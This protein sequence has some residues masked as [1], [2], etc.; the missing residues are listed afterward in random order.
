MSC[1]STDAALSWLLSLYSTCSSSPFRPSS[2]AENFDNFTDWFHVSPSRSSPPFQDVSS[3]TRI[4]LPQEQ[5]THLLNY[6]YGFPDMLDISRAVSQSDGLS[7]AS[8]AL[9]TSIFNL[10][11][12][13]LSL[14]SSSTTLV[15][16]PSQNSLAILSPTGVNI[17]HEGLYQP[18]MS[19]HY[20]SP[21]SLFA[22][23]ASRLIQEFSQSPFGSYY[24]HSA[25]IPSLP[26]QS[27]S[28]IS[29]V[30]RADEQS[31]LVVKDKPATKS[32]KKKR[33]TKLPGSQMLPFEEKLRSMA[34]PFA[35]PAAA[36]ILPNALLDAPPSVSATAA[37]LSPVKLSTVPFDFQEAMVDTDRITFPRLGTI[38]ELGEVPR[39]PVFNSPPAIELSPLTPLTPISSPASPEKPCKL[40][41]R[42]PVKR[43]NVDA[44]T[45]VRRSKRPRRTVIIDSSSPLA[46]PN[47]S[48]SVVGAMQKH[49]P[50]NQ[51][52]EPVF[53][54][55]RLPNIKI[56][57]GFPLFY[58]RFPASSYYQPA[59]VG[60]AHSILDH[61]NS[62]NFQH[63]SPCSLFNVA[64][65]GGNYNPPRRVFDLYT[66]RFVKGKGAEKVGLCPICVESTDRGGENKKLWLAMKFSAF[67][68]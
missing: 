26:A 33:K 27:L 42:I 20:H 49:P 16:T 47:S 40:K 46:E 36:D 35:S 31:K 58:R 17:D 41:I 2:P 3:S 32:K 10:H 37:L 50:E 59:G 52:A 15:N 64:H 1:S 66:P 43:K 25:A 19:P 29:P 56:S 9:P 30:V 68:W 67:K 28:D 57:S 45:P 34:A 5:N 4:N 23:P 39:T 18:P 51:N 22:S 65:P 6:E 63:S 13:M 7:D 24:S 54:N 44:S 38:S 21:T 61:V 14:D 62:T 53:T 11:D 8:A 48:P 12:R 55:R 60:Y